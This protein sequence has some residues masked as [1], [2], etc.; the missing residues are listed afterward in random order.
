M[1]IR[2]YQCFELLQLG[3]LFRLLLL[4]HRIAV[5]LKEEH[6]HIA[7]PRLFRVF[8]KLPHGFTTVSNRE[9]LSVTLLS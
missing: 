8:R 7:C 4:A 2:F 3:R 5:I 1:C 6:R 9:R